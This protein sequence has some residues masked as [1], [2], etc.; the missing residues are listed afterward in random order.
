MEGGGLDVG[1]GFS[2]PLVNFNV[3]RLNEFVKKKKKRGE[4]ERMS[5]HG[6]N[7]SS[8]LFGS[9]TVVIFRKKIVRKG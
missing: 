3:T 6:R 8:H 7:F 4:R 1:K 5:L 9:S 2:P